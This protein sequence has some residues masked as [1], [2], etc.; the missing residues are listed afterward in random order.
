[1]KPLR[2]FL[3]V[4]TTL[5]IAADWRL[6]ADPMFPFLQEGSARTAYI[7][8]VYEGCMKGLPPSPKSGP[9]C[10]CFGRA[11]ADIINSKELEE[12][13]TQGK[14]PASLLKKGELS[15]NVC[16]SNMTPESQDT[17]RKHE[18]V[19]ETNECLTIYHPEETDMAA[20]LM[21]T[22]FCDCL[23]KGIVDLG[24]RATIA[25]NRLQ[26]TNRCSKLQ[27]DPR[28]AQP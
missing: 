18:I 2:V 14:N 21:R 11:L 27:L 24:A 3:I 23:A 28:A 19:R 17:I 15:R 26:V 5:P 9:Y 6:L 16:L 4:L 25:D 10:L 13:I 20:S 8:G 22:T 1:M 12:Q 7:G